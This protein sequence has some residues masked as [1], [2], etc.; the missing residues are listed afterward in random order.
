[1]ILDAKYEKDNIDTNINTQVASEYQSPSFIIPKK[2]GTVRIVFD[3]RAL[4]S[5]AQR[6]VFP[7]PKNIGHTYQLKRIYKCHTIDLYMGNYTIVLTP[8]A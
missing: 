2:N 1:L 5:K 3:F 6:V 4:N 7:I 8:Q